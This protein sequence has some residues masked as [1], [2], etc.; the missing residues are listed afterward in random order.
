MRESSTLLLKVTSIS[1]LNYDT[2]YNCTT[3]LSIQSQEKFTSTTIIL[4]GRRLHQCFPAIKIESAFLNH[5][6]G[7]F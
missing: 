1:K 7:A 4:G 6:N 5:D 3:S 2:F